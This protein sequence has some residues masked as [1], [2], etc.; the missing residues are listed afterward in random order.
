MTSVYELTTPLGAERKQRFWDYFDGNGLRN[1]WTF[2]NTTGTGS[3]GMNDSIN[4][5]AFIT[6]GSNDLDRSGIAFNNK[7]Q[8]D[9][10]SF[11]FIVN[12]K[13]PTATDVLLSS[14]LNDVV[15][16]APERIIYQIFDDT[17][18][19]ID[20]TRIQTY[21]GVSATATTVTS[22]ITTNWYNARITSDATTAKVWE[23]G[24]FA[25]AKTTN[26]PASQKS[27]PYLEVMARSASARSGYINY[28]ECY[29]T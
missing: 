5:G 29:N 24:D 23:N 12:I 16:A 17:S 1:W 20:E 8:Y 27:Q 2:F 22:T 26:I 3:S 4:D 13:V 9:L 28:M 7:R 25:T 18:D 11:M 6:S 10:G 14:G 15:G 19:V 21:D